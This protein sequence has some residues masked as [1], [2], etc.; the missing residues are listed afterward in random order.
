[1]TSILV[2]TPCYHGSVSMEYAVSMLGL[3]R[4][5]NRDGIDFSLEMTGSVSL[6]PI[7]RNYIVAKL[8]GEPRFTHLLFIDADI[9]FDPAVVPRY[10][11]A[12]KDIV[13]GV[14][15]LKQ[16]D[17]AAMRNLPRERP[18]AAALH[19]A[20]RI[21]AGERPTADGFVKAEYAATGF[22]LIR[23]GVLERMAARY[24]ELKY[25]HS[26]TL[27]GA[28]DGAHLYA[29]FD[30][31]LDANGVYLPED[32][33]F[34]ARWRAMGGEIWV[35]AR[36]KFTHVGRQVFAGDYSAARGDA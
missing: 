17:L 20:A 3:Q 30:T 33:T 22:M 36:S 25:R 32:Y 14:Y 13:A 6:I 15:P 24:P 21:G 2:G 16:L 35:D 9:G 7:A 29:L 31:S 12:D 18:T 8:L 34:C 10:L 26:F 1:M 11:A 28:I 23:R 27:G 5:L 4:E 19:Y